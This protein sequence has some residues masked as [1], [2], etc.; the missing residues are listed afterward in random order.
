MKHIWTGCFD[1]YC[2]VGS[3]SNP[4]IWSLNKWLC[5]YWTCYQVYSPCV[6]LSHL[7]LYC[8]LP[9]N[10]AHWCSVYTEY[11]CL[12]AFSSFQSCITY[13]FIWLFRWAFLHLVSATSEPKWI[14]PPPV[15]LWCYKGHPTNWKKP[16]I[17][18]PNKLSP[19][20]EYDIDTSLMDIITMM[21]EKS[22]GCWVGSRKSLSS[23]CIIYRKII[24][25][26]SLEWS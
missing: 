14:F 23:L 9:I 5:I 7:A 26:L 6:A 24:T 1:K 12:S 3:R 10:Y 2:L 8:Q 13:L 15:T 18:P 16:T 19:V 11:C 4:I 25:W 20:M 22:I 21:S 17:W